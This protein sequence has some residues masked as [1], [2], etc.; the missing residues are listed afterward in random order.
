MAAV[1]GLFSIASGIAGGSAAEQSGKAGA[2]AHEYN[3]NI[4]ERNAERAREAATADIIGLKRTEYKTVGAQRAG[5]GAAG[6]SSTSGSAL[7]VLAESTSMAVLDQQR[8]RYQGDIE[9]A[10]QKNAATISLMNAYSVKEGG[11]ATAA[12][13]VLSGAASGISRFTPT[14][15]QAPKLEAQKIPEKIE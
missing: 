14:Q 2:E 5:Y 12:S 13:S 11:Q 9:Y 6:V 4:Q 15:K 3:Y 10:D 8:R 7:D 1:S